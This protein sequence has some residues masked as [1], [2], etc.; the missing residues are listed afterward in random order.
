[1]EIKIKEVLEV[2]DKMSKENR[3]Y[4]LTTFKGEDGKLYKE[5]YGEFKEG[6]TVNG[7]WGK[8]KF[9]NDKFEVKRPTSGRGF[10]GRSEEERLEIIRQSCVERALLHF[11]YQGKTD[12]TKENVVLLSEY[13]VKYVKEGLSDTTKS[14]T[15]VTPPQSQ[16]TVSAREEAPTPSDEDFDKEFPKH[17]EEIDIEDIPL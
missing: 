5:V 8:D 1:M 2:L 17:E 7:E 14:K 16:T 3:P 6:E 15:P 4:K 12:F 13:Y 9:G 11:Y 10:G